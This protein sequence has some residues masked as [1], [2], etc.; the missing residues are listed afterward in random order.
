MQADGGFE[1]IYAVKNRYPF[2]FRRGQFIIAV[3]P[4]ERT[5]KAPFAFSGSTVF[6]IGGHEVDNGYLVMKPQTLL[7]MKL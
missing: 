3:N 2:I 4:T 7:L 5:E 6:E 1:V